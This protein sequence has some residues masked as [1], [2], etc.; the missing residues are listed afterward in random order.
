MLSGVQS[1]ESFTG[2]GGL[3]HVQGDFLPLWLWVQSLTR[4]LKSHKPHGT[5]KEKE[6]IIVIFRV[7]FLLAES[8][9]SKGMCHLLYTVINWGGLRDSSSYTRNCY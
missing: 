3:V 7:L 1:S 2:A 9:N 4:E 8:A 6:S 5:T